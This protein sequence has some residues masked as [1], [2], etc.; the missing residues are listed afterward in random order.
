MLCLPGVLPRLPGVELSSCPHAPW[1]T[2]PC[3][4]SAGCSFSRLSPLLLCV[5]L[6]AALQISIQA[7]AESQQEDVS[8][9]VLVGGSD[10]AGSPGT[11]RDPDNAGNA[12]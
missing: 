8:S 12:G 3:S 6:G 2:V 4:K 9:G 11:V 1:F 5:L 10:P 7:G